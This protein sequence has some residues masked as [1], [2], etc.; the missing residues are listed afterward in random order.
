[1]YECYPASCFQCTL[2]DYVCLFVCFFNKC[3]SGL[4][5]QRPQDLN[6]YQTTIGESERYI[7]SWGQK[8]KPTSTAPWQPLSL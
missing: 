4:S 8:A 6:E 3:E 7:N 2:A 1:M 5:A